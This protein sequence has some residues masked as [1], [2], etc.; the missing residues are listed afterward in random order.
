[1]GDHP[2][3]QEAK[4]VIYFFS[5]IMETLDAIWVLRTCVGHRTGSGESAAGFAGELLPL[6]QWRFGS[7]TRAML[8]AAFSPPTIGS[9]TAH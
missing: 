9:G 1:M 8:Q 4:A 6:S 7:E 5:E 2:F 3:G